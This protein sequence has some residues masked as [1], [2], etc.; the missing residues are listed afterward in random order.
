MTVELYSIRILISRHVEC[1]KENWKQVEV[2][3]TDT[4][5]N[6]CGNVENMTLIDLCDGCSSDMRM[7]ESVYH[8]KNK[9]QTFKFY[10]HSACLV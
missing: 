6:R 2:T 5:C 7:E 9:F 1:G 4:G 10:N 3:V 8:G